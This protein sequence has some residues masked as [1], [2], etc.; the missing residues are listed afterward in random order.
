[1]KNK[2]RVLSSFQVYQNDAFK[3]YLEN[4]ALKGFRLTKIGQMFL[5]FEACPPHPIRYCVEVMEKPSAFRSIQIPALIQYR[6]FCQ[7]A[8]W[9]YA[10]TNGYLHVFCTEDMDAVPVETDP[11]ERYTRIRKANDGAYLVLTVM[12]LILAFLCPNI[13]CT[14]LLIGTLLFFGIDYLLWRNRARVSLNTSGTLPVQ[15]WKFVKTRNDLCIGIITVL[16]LCSMLA[17]SNILKEPQTAV[18]LLL[19]LVMYSLLI[20]F[21]SFLIRSLRE[22]H[23]FSRTANILIYWGVGILLTVLITIIALVFIFL[24]IL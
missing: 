5:T 9:E 16:M 24:F 7:D 23:S 2:K 18:F 1:M 12:F 22:K 10:G 19:Y 11:A 15:S 17:S 3:D 14:L 13:F 4:M 8:G 6:E 20:M 21:F